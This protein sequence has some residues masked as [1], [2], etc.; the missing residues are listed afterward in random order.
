MNKLFSRFAVGILLTTSLMAWEK[1]PF[2]ESVEN[3]D[4]ESCLELLNE[5]ATDIEKE[6]FLIALKKEIESEYDII[7]QKEDIFLALEDTYCEIKA[8]SP[9]YL[10][11]ALLAD[12]DPSFTFVK[13]KSKKK[14]FLDKFKNKSTIYQAVGGALVCLVPI[15]G[16]RIIGTGIIT[17]AVVRAARS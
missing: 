6:T 12:F 9:A 7:I 4:L 17:D 14:G 13:S 3:Y 8:N 5:F 2:L 16:A 10:N 15:P 11:L 1:E